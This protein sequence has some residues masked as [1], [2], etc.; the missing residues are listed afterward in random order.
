MNKLRLSKK[1]FAI[2]V[3]SLLASCSNNKDEISHTNDTNNLKAHKN[4]LINI[5][6][7]LFSVPSPIES[8][9]FI[10]KT[11][12]PY[13]KSVLNNHNANEFK[14]SFF[15]AINL[16]SYGADLGYVTIYEQANEQLKYLAQAKKLAEKLGILNLFDAETMKKFSGNIN[17]KD[18]I[19]GLVGAAYRESDNYLKT[20]HRTE[21]SNLILVGG[22]VE[23]LNLAAQ[24]NKIKPTKELE[25]RIAF[26]KQ[27]LI[28]ILKILENKNNN[29]NTLE[30]VKKLRELERIYHKVVFVYKYESPETD[31]ENKTTKI[32]S[33][34]EV[35]ISEL[36]ITEITEKIKDIR[37]YC[38]GNV[39]P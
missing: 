2:S 21:T 19:L 18:S 37:D 27:A 22:W 32:N 12:V 4:N 17:K 38:V 25:T 33:S 3:L 34:T 36:Q 20:H 28:S 29:E 14:T 6:G 11:S 16:G 9:V 15:Q 24:I 10:R 5:G 30:L 23:S 13:N 35:R 31:E 39:K 8:S 26:Q 1:I 7:E